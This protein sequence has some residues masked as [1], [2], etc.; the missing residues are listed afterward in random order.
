MFQ[1]VTEDVIVQ[2]NTFFQEK[3]SQPL[4]ANFIFA[5]R[6]VIKNISDDTIR[7]LRR[8]W[9]IIDS[10]GSKEEVAGDGVVGLQPIL[11]PYSKHEYM[12]GCHLR[13]DLGKMYGTYEMERQKDG[14]LFQVTIPEFTLVVPF[15]MN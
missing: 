8:H 3:A 12:S 11:T 2:V 13:T 15:R 5:Y 7:L 9:H 6:I 4:Y 14:S 1:A 10:N